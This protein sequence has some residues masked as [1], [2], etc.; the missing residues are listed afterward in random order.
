MPKALSILFGAALTVSTAHALGR[1]LLSRTGFR[2]SREET[3]LYGFL[4]GAPVLSLAIF[5]LG[6]CGLVY[7]AS[8]LILAAAAHTAAWRL[9]AFKQDSLMLG[10]LPRLW[11]WLFWIPYAVFGVVAVI[12]AMAPESSPDGASYHL[13]VVQRYYR[14]HALVRIETNMYANLSQGVEMLFLMAWAFGRHSAAALAH[15]AYYLALPL[16][17]LRFGQRHGH[18]A[19]GAAAALFTMC[20]PLMLVDGTSAYIDVAVA[21]SLFAVFALCEIEAPALLLG[22]L[23]GACFGMKYT[24]ALAVPYAGV[25]LLLR[26]RWRDVAVFAAAA[27]LMMLPWLV[28]NAAWFQN[29]FSP[30]L[31]AWF[32]N[33]WIH[34]SFEQDYANLMRH[35]VGL[36]SD[37]AIPLEVTIR[38]RVL[39]GF[40]G[41]LFLL[42]P[43]ALLSLRSAL[44][45]RL[46][47]AAVLFALP[48]AANI[49]TRFLL[50][51]L[52]FVSLA[53]ALAPPAGLA[54]WMLPLLVV[55]HAVSSFPDMPARYADE[56]GWRVPRIP[57][58]QALR[59][60]SE[61]SWLTY[62]WPPYRLAKMIEQ[63]T[64]EG[65]R[66][67]S[68]SPL[69]ESYTTRE[70]AVGYQSALGERMRDH[71]YTGLIT[72]FQ[73][74]LVHT[75]E[76]ETRD[77]SALRVVQT[78]HPARGA[79]VRDLWSIT[80][81]R[82]FDGHRELERSPGWRITARPNPWDAGLAFDG[83]PLTRWRS[84]QW[85]KGGWYVEAA[86]GSP[87]RVSRVALEMSADQYAVR[88]RLD[89]RSEA[90]EWKTLVPNP[91]TRGM[92][93]PLGLR[94]LAT[95]ELKRNGF[96][97]ILV[98][99]DDF[100]W[101][102]Y[103]D[104]AELWGIREAGRVDN[105]RL[106]RIE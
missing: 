30:L 46:L 47:A 26:K 5:A 82:V 84:W 60:E 106:Y 81:F 77:L 34:V 104:K 100:R 3:P 44:G 22:L 53:M 50:P 75:F 29:P 24:A 6:A 93:P 57:L 67:F 25:R 33:P 14:E 49:G 12:A 58:R 16:L 45:R 13:G 42:A 85:L 2:L 63:S 32:P 37:A 105:F 101:Q 23:A 27:A 51:A 8:F 10:P 31:N 38:G 96:T 41:P 74:A 92:A 43:A 69:P 88:M 95:E 87:Q 15:C 17:L 62:K 89:G 65:A 72:D 20:S 7:D 39:N 52:P 18:P 64:P 102:D 11:R 59:I 79:D 97:H 80:E 28:R 73:P 71:L 56:Y 103:R 86:F 66:V 36:E 99:E 4:L 78:A 55:A 90:G 48:Y 83:S 98:S 1:L 68:F 94:R 54:R 19:A 91:I 9:G 35:Y 40:L 61:E 76:F 21:A 70:I